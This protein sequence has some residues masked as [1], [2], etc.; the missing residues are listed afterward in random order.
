MEGIFNVRPMFVF[1]ENL[2]N[3]LTRGNLIYLIA[4]VEE[5]QVVQ[6]QKVQKILTLKADVQD[7]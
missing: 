1:M 2:T 5:Q 6:F 7:F 4:D 3:K